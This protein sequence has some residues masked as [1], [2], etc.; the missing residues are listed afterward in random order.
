MTVEP[1]VV[2][3]ESSLRITAMSKISADSK[4]KQARDEG[5]EDIPNK[6]SSGVFHIYPPQFGCLSGDANT[7]PQPVQATSEAEM[8]TNWTTPVVFG[9]A[10]GSE[11]V[12]FVSSALLS[13]DLNNVNL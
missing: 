5:T 11:V 9:P 1:P 2:A 10:L 13:V 4:K 3:F 6:I 7:Y 12:R 8:R